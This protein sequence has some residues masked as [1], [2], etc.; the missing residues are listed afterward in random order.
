M[1]QNL[2]HHS[3]IAKLKVHPSIHRSGIHTAKGSRKKF[4]YHHKGMQ[5]MANK[6]RETL[7]SHTLEAIY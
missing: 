2:E 7:K 1:H 5:E 6:K 4:I 3:E